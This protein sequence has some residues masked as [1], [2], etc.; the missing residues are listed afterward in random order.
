MTENDR[1]MLVIRVYASDSM[2]M[3]AI[4]KCYLIDTESNRPDAENT[5]TQY[6]TNHTKNLVC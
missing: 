6:A 4:W 3:V 5:E 2:A 1:E